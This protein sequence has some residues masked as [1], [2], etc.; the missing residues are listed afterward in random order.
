[1]KL[2]SY[3][4]FGTWLLERQLKEPLVNKIEEILLFAIDSG[5]RHFDTATVYG[6][7]KIEEILGACLQ[8]DAII[9]TK[10]PAITKPYL[11]SPAPIQKFYSRN[12]IKCSVEGSLGRLRRIS[13]DT[14]LLHNWLPS[15]STDA[16][17][18]LWCLKEMKEQGITR[19][20]GISLPDNFSSHIAQEVLPYIDVIEAPFNPE[21]RWVLE[22][23]PTLLELKKEVILRSLFD[24]G[25][26]LTEHSAESLVQDALKLGTSIVI[27]MTKKEQITQN[28][29]YLK[30]GK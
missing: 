23:L 7:G 6:G 28:I 3:L 30:G 9:V 12:H 18:I 11:Q 20:V 16:I 8:E 27:G 5:I 2:S 29:N 22:Q 4:Y 13:V 14:I 25:K 24:Q 26:L 21:Q 10:I 15:W 19:R 17:E 1:M